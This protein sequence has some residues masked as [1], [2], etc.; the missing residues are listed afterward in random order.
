MATSLYLYWQLGVSCGEYFTIHKHRLGSHVCH[1]A[2]CT[3]VCT[4]V[5]LMRRD[6]IYD[7]AW[8]HCMCM[9]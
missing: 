7:N 2:E 3:Y 4:Y 6:V 8:E 9:E 1:M 5:P